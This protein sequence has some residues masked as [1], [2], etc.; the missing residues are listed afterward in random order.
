[1]LHTELPTSHSA[2][3]IE[4]QPVEVGRNHCSILVCTNTT[5]EIVST[6][7][8]RFKVK[9][10]STDLP[11]SQYDVCIVNCQGNEI[12]ITEEHGQINAKV[13]FALVDEHSYLPEKHSDKNAE[14]ELIT[15]AELDSDILRLRIESRL[16]TI[17]IQ[18]RQLSKEN[19]IVKEN[20]YEIL[21]L[22]M[23]YSTDWMVVKDL[24]H[25][26]ALVT[27]RYLENNQKEATEVIGKNDL[28]IGTPKELV[29]GSKEK[30]WEGFWANDNQVIA[31]KIPVESAQLILDENAFGQKQEYVSRVP[32]QNA[33]GDVIGLFVCIAEAHTANINGDVVSIRTSRREVDLSA[34]I[35]KLDDDRSKAEAQNLKSQSD[36]KR[37]NNFIATASHDLRQPLHAIGLFIESLQKTEINSKQKEILLKMKKSSSDLNELLNSILD[38]S[39][40]DADAVPVNKTHFAIAPLLK[41]IEDEFETEAKAKSIHLH[42]NSSSS[43]VH[44]DSL[45]LS[46]ILKN[47]VSNAV[48]YT[49]TGSVNLITEVDDSHLS[50]CIKD[51][52]PGIPKEQYQSVFLEYNQLPNLNAQPNFG[53]GLGLSIVKRLVELLKLDISL[54]SEIDQGTQFCLLVP[55]GDSQKISQSQSPRKNLHFAQ[56]YKLLVVEDNAPVLE[57]MEEMLTSMDCD[58]YPAHD[59]SEALE[60]IHEVE[61]LPDLLIVDYQL[62]GGVTGDTAIE[63]IRLAAKKNIPAIIVTGNTNS[64]LVRKATE[65]A[66]R[67]LSKPVNPDALLRSIASAIEQHESDTNL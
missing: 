41:S 63:Q 51:T 52:G 13:V 26:F 18:K 23:R 30:D 59:I 19:D 14:L 48:K 43:V 7:A 40:L 20:A 45:L 38:I 8:T 55:L 4:D 1:M 24:D 9:R 62:A 56:S 15:E 36:I 25:R 16:R 32:I 46:R 57:A 34:I 54:D 21:Q 49:S 12:S 60:I 44:S 35:K 33:N 29:L 37:K 42:I 5:P 3:V 64:V 22:V 28:E 47:L 6:L 67:V 31:S 11:P 50:I 27:N 17:Q 10:Y 66:Y 2:D 65:S 39:K 53:Q 58:T 61:E